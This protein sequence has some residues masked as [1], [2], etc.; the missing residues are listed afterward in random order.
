M[1]DGI[2]GELV[3]WGSND[4]G[5]CGDEDSTTFVTPLTTPTKVIGIAESVKLVRV[6]QSHSCALM[7]SGD[8][9][10]WGDNWA[11]QCGVD[12]ATTEI[13][14]VPR[15][16]V[17]LPSPATHLAV[18]ASHTCA[19]LQGGGVMCWGFG[20]DGR[21][22][23]GNV[24]GQ[25][26]PTPHAVIG[27]TDSVTSFD[28]DYGTT[29]AL[30]A[31][32]SLWCWGENRFGGAGY[33]VVA[34]D[35]TVAKAYVP[36]QVDLSGVSGE[37]TSVATGFWHTCATT[38]AG[39]LYCWG[40]NAYNQ[41]G[42]ASTDHSGCPYTVTPT[43]CTATPRLVANIAG[44]TSVSAG[45]SHTCATL[46]DGGA[47]CWG[48]TGNGGNIWGILG[49]GT[50]ASTGTHSYVPKVVTRTGNPSPTDLGNA[51]AVVLG[52]NFACVEMRDRTVECWGDNNY[53]QLGDPAYTSQS[54]SSSRTVPGLVTYRR[55]CTCCEA[56]LLSV[57]LGKKG[58]CVA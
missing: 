56:K 5:Q 25:N 46:A 40:Y 16:V 31:N 38:D 43:S 41:V 11:G 53:G 22:G 39:S 19:A 4:K 28:A 48:W 26:I 44:V 55:T 8:V 50:T 54:A 35:N 17:G 14:R 21:L 58:E 27:I 24:D 57:G 32:A 29:C 12:P 52:D 47:R 51:T 34:S 37:I 30:L 7:S 18:G 13:I 1:G 15:K 6:G 3:C 2:V 9:M 49:D 20:T 10:C 42:Y 23:Y 33:G 36:V 45:T